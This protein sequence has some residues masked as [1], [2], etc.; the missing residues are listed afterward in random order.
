MK[1]NFPNAKLQT[2]NILKHFYETEK[3]IKDYETDIKQISEKIQTDVSDSKIK[4]IEKTRQHDFE[5]I[6]RLDSELI[7]AENLIKGFV[8]KAESLN[9]KSESA[10]KKMQVDKDLHDRIELTKNTLKALEEI[11]NNYTEYAKKQLSKAATQIFIKL[12]DTEG[13]KTLRDVIVNDNYSLQINN[14][15]GEPFLANISSGQRQI[16]SVSFIS[17]LALMASKSNS[18]TNVIQMPLFMDTPFGRLSFEHRKNL[19]QNIP[20]YT[21]QWILLATDTEF[22]EMEAKVLYNTGKWARIYRLD[23][24]EDG[25]TQIKELGINEAIKTFAAI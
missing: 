6:G 24:S 5:A 1:D 14:D 18:S 25:S 9:K 21:S 12:I 11:L 4:D 16:L 22:G 13:K 10:F 7:R 17:A 15:F 8:E 3:I 20:D 2:K 23:S 19:I